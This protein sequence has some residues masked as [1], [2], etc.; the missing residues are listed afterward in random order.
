[1]MAIFLITSCFQIRH[2]DERGQCLLVL[3]GALA[4]THRMCR[5]LQEKTVQAPVDAG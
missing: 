3:L 1:V 2:D 4:L 5:P